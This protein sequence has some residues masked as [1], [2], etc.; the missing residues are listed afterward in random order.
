ML[1]V[2]ETVNPRVPAVPA[3]SLDRDRLRKAF[4][5]DGYL[6]FPGVVSAERLK[7]L[8]QQLSEAFETSKR[9]GRLFAGGGTISGHL[10][11]SPGEAARFAYE[12]LETHGIIG[13]VKELFPKATRL[14]NV[15]CNFNLPHSVA[16]HYHADRNFL[17]YFMIANVAVVDTTIENGAID[18]IPGTHKKFYKYWRFAVER[19]AR[20]SKRIEMK[21]GD[22]LV[23]TSNVWHRGMPNF[24]NAPRPML[25]FTWEDGGSTEPDPFKTDDGEIGFKTNWYQPTM[26][27]RMR[28]R[29]FV[30]A[31]IT[32]SAYRFV[33]S[34]YGT[35]GYDHQ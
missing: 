28:E 6:I 27:G 16:Q 33:T 21:Q 30:A 18:I 35:K 1:Q 29:T 4:A 10:N 24:T 3:A 19:A 22:V 20:G 32:Y 12:A 5:E 23:R 31:P 17:D 13:L 8:H 26:L 11:C 15:G 2:A 9:S 34:L 7:A 14:P 25:A